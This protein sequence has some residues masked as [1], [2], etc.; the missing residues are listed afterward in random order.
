MY[1]NWFQTNGTLMKDN[2]IQFNKCV[3]RYINQTKK[4]DAIIKKGKHFFGFYSLS[5]TLAASLIGILFVGIYFYRKNNF[6]FLTPFRRYKKLDRSSLVEN[7]AEIDQQQRE[8]D[9]IV[10][11]LESPPFNKFSHAPTHV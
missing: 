9:E 3:N 7:A 6:T 1:A 4:L 8:D 10:M 5:I 2:K 11:N